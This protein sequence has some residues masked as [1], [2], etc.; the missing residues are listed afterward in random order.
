MKGS[1]GDV[2]LTIFFA[3]P[4]W[5]KQK[6]LM[7]SIRYAK[8]IQT[9]LLPSERHINKQLKKLMSHEGK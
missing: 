9:A 6:E 8:R 2:C 4:S 1:E 5:Q 7:D 3:S